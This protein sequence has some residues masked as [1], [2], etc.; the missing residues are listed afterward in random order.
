VEFENVYSTDE[1]GLISFIDVDNK[2]YIYTAFYVY[3]AH[4]V[5]QFLINLISNLP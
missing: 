4:R 2:Q 1:R 3:Y 5:L